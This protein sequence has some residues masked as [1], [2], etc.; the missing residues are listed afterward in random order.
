MGGESR[1]RPKIGGGAS[2]AAESLTMRH[3]L[4]PGAFRPRIAQA[5]GG[6]ENFPRPR[7]D[8]PCAGV[9]AYLT[10]DRRRNGE[11][12]DGATARAA[13]RLDQSVLAALC[14]RPYPR[15]QAA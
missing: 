2:T 11:R 5:S 9:R 8:F 6:E 3:F 13:T 14:W 10:E 15:W 1:S 4:A 7:Y 12:H